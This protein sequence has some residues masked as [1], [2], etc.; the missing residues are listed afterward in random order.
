VFAD[1]P[2]GNLDSARTA[3]VLGLLRHLNRTRGQTFVIVTH[4]P[5]VGAACDRIIRMRDGHVVGQ[6]G[7]I[8][9]A[10]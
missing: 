6:E 3:E 8:A 9:A 1:E 10:A 2:T 5:D 7:R 4:D